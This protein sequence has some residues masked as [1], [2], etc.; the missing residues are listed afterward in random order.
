M[1]S[2][3][4][5]CL[6]DLTFDL[7][8]NKQKLEKTVKLT[9]KRTKKYST[10]DRMLKSEGV[11]RPDRNVTL[12]GHDFACYSSNP[13]DFTTFDNDC[14]NGAKNVKLLCFNS[15]KGKYDFKT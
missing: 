11:S 2:S 10:I 15:I 9:P 13:I 6:K 3:A 12:D 7:F 8:N 1:K 5:S 4:T 14:F